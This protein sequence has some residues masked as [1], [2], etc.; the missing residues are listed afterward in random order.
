M[1]ENLWKLRSKTRGTPGVGEQTYTSEAGFIFALETARRAFAT[2]MSA[3]LPD[4]TTLDGA[5]LMLRY[6]A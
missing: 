3:T 1:T 2:D 5:A 6:P 4:G